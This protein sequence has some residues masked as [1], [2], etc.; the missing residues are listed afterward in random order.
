[1]IAKIFHI[2]D[3]VSH[4]VIAETEEQAKDVIRE[5]YEEYGYDPEEAEDLW[6]SMKIRQLEPSDKLT[7]DFERTDKMELEVGN[8]ITL[9]YMFVN[10]EDRKP[11]Y[12]ACSEY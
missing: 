11:M 1:M 5:K 3:G 12:W 7:M 9:Y 6:E 4:W 10:S 8:W 2:D